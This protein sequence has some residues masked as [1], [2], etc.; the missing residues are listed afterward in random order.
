MERARTEELI[1]LAHVRVDGQDRQA[2]A[3][4]L[5]LYLP[6]WFWYKIMPDIP[7]YIICRALAA[8]RVVLVAV[9]R[10]LFWQG[11]GPEV[12]PGGG[13]ARLSSILRTGPPLTIG[14]VPWPTHAGLRLDAAL[15]RSS[16]L[17]R[18]SRLLRRWHG[19]EGVVSRW[20]YRLALLT[21]RGQVL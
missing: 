2:T 12:V 3:L 20:R 7:K 9:R 13:R 16:E 1:E 17:P 19:R 14:H 18:L 5:L 8:A 6:G 4:S 21:S 15:S 10:V 11:T